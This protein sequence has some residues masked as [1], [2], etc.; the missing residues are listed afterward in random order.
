MPY[1]NYTPNRRFT[2]YTLAMVDIANGILEEYEEQGFTLT[3]R[4][5]YYQ[6]VAR[7]LFPD[8][9]TW[10]NTGGNKWKRDPNGTKNADPNYDWLGGIMSDARMAGLVDWNHLIDRTR[11]LKDLE[12]F[13]DAEDALTKLAGWYH[14]DMWENQAVR[15]EVW[16]EKDALVGVIQ[17]I[18]QRLDVPFFSCRGYTSM[19]EMWGAGQRLA[20]HHAAGYD[21]HIIHL[22]DHD[23]SGV[24]MT[25][26]IFDRLEVFM[27]GTEVNRIALTMEQIEEHQ[28]PPN[29]AKVTDSRAKAYIKRFGHKSW[30][31]DALQPTTLAGLIE[32]AVLAIR[33]EAVWR[34]DV[35]RKA[36]VKGHLKGIAARW[37]DAQNIEAIMKELERYR[38]DGDNS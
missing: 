23:P 25:R 31:L 29:P 5:L 8:D 9:R 1:I 21:T 38:A 12:H 28:P 14:V 37:E 34:E 6:I 32:G 2:D 18:C 22:G 17:P 30:E 26:D 10:V 11:N 7:D 4:Q 19:S 13:V 35:A 3:L 36:E 16:V 27:G 33:D 24:D 15:P 20:R